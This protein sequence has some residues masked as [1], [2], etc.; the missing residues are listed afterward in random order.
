MYHVLVDHNSIENL[1]VK[2]LS[3][4]IKLCT[5]AVSVNA[6]STA[7]SSF[8]VSISFASARENTEGSG[9]CINKL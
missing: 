5:L 1:A 8:S 9:V 6:A 3:N 4:E 2:M 7:D